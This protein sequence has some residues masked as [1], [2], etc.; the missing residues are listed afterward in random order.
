MSLFPIFS[1]AKAAVITGGFQDSAIN[2]TNQTDF[3]MGTVDIG[4]A[5]DDRLCVVLLSYEGGHSANTVTLASISLSKIAD[6]GNSISEVTIWTGVVASGTTGNLSMTGGGNS[7][8]CGGAVYSL[9]G[10]NATAEDT[11]TSTAS[12][13]TGSLDISAGGIGM[14]LSV[15]RVTGSCSWAGLAERF[16]EAQESGNPSWW[17]AADSTTEGSGTTVTSTWSSYSSPAMAAAS[18]QPA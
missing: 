17:S 15:S 8:S 10:A 12:P 9:Y 4:T 7:S 5:A 18:F 13:Q 3:D 14:A 6:A 11:M 2:T 16:D 1:P